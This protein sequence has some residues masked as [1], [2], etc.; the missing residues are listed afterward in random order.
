MQR[1]AV[2]R[3]QDQKQQIADAAVNAAH[4]HYVF[5][6]DG[7]SYISFEEEHEPDSDGVTPIG[8]RSPDPVDVVIK[9]LNRP[10]WISV[11]LRAAALAVSLV[12][13][14]VAIVWSE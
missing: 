3:R 4:V 7:G 5:A 9:R 8:V 6:M 13:V 12:A 1:F 14:L 2:V 10:Y 11:A